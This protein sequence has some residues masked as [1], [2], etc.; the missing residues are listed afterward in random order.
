MSRNVFM[1]RPPHSSR[2]LVVIAVAAASS[3]VAAGVQLLAMV[4][5][6]AL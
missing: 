1:V 3:C 5:G 2:A 4:L 6:G